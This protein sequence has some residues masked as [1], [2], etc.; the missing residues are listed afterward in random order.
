[1]LSSDCGVFCDFNAYGLGFDCHIA[2]VQAHITL[3]G[4][5]KDNTPLAVLFFIF[6][7]LSSLAKDRNQRLV[8]Y[9]REDSWL[10]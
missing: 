7:S 9:V 2:T 3:I 1:M 5:R 10:H 4:Q 6:I 8:I